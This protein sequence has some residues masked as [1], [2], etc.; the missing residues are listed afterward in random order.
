[1]TVLFII[2]RYDDILCIHFECQFIYG[3]S[4]YNTDYNYNYYNY[5]D[6]NTENN[7]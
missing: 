1:M 6:Y 4:D 2:C 5:C 3:S 7:L